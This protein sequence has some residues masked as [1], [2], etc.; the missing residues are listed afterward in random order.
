MR[1]YIDNT[2]G[3]LFVIPTQILAEISSI[4]GLVAFKVFPNNFY[5]KWKIKWAEKLLKTLP[6]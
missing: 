5:L 3:W 2:I 6:K 1:K 4:L